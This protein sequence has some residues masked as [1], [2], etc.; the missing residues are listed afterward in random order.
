VPD[1][2][3]IISLNIKKQQSCYSSHEGERGPHSVE[4]VG[5]TLYQ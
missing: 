1:R 4:D 3:V 2:F 5:W